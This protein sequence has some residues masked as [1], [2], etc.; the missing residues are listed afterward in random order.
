MR[1]NAVFYWSSRATVI[2]KFKEYRNQM[3]ESRDPSDVLVRPSTRRDESLPGIP[4]CERI[5]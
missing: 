2:E 5:G 3:G 1:K 4:H